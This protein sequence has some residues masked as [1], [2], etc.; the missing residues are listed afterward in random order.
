[1]KKFSKKLMLAAALLVIAVAFTTPARAHAV[2]IIPMQME[3]YSTSATPVYAAPD[4][5][6][7]IVT[8]LERFINVRVTGITE[9]GFFVVDLNGPFYI[10]G[11]YLVPKVEKEKSASQKAHDRLDEV[12]EIYRTQLQMMDGTWSKFALKD[13]TGDGVPE[14][15]DDAGKEIYSFYDDGEHMRL[16]ILYYSENPVTFYYSKNNNKLL[17]KYRW[18]DKDY[19]E[20]YTKDTTYVPWGQFRC[21]ST[22]ASAYTGNATAIERDRDNN[23]ET[24]NDLYNILHELLGLGS[25]ENH[26]EDDK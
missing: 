10:P 13:V 20:V 26:P 19:W 22:D 7:P 17:G 23:Q 3:M 18:N 16:V 1:M 9:N 4:V 6:S 12:T 21:F 24:R 11:A 15:I 8:H 5:F 14:L 25:A 2:N